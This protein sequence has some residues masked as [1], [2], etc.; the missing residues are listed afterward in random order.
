MDF[1]CGFRSVFPRGKFHCHLNIPEGS[2]K[3]TVHLRSTIS[4]LAVYFNVIYCS[5]LSAISRW[6]WLRGSAENSLSHHHYF[7]S[8]STSVCVSDIP[9][10][11]YWVCGPLRRSGIGVDIPSP[12][13]SLGFGFFDHLMCEEILCIVHRATC[14]SPVVHLHAWPATHPAGTSETCSATTARAPDIMH[15]AYL[16]SITIKDYSFLFQRS[17]VT[18][19]PCRSSVPALPPWVG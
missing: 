13:L 6:E 11:G 15:I 5:L 16:R 17:V 3:V 2:K 18:A 4:P 8:L 14:C 1:R 10:C 9:G 12:A 19:A 7:I